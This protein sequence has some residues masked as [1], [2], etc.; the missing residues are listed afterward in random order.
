[1]NDRP[2]SSEAA[3]HL[4]Q[5]GKNISG[6][7]LRRI[8]TMIMSFGILF[9]LARWLGADGLGQYNLAIFFPSLLMTFLNLGVR[10]SNAYHIGQNRAN[11]SVAIRTVLIL[12]IV[13]TGIGVIAGVIL[14]QTFA[15]VLFPDVPENYLW[16]ALCAF[17]ILLL[18]G[19]LFGIVQGLQDFDLLNRL[20][21]VISALNLT[22]V[23]V[24]SV[25][26][27]L[28]VVTALMAY[29]LSQVAGML[30]ALIMLLRYPPIAGTADTTSLLDFG[31]QLVR[32][33]WLLNVSNIMVFLNYRID[34]F[35]INLVLNPTAVGLY[36]TA[37][38]VVEVVWMPSTAVG[39]VLI[40]RIAELKDDES[41]RQQITPLIA[42]WT[43]LVTLC[44]SLV[45]IVMGPV[46][47]DLIGDEYAQAYPVL[48]LLLPGAI[49][50]THSRVLINDVA[51]RGFPKYH[52]YTTF[53]VLI[54]E[55]SLL[56][57]FTPPLGLIG[58]AVA[59]SLA[60]STQVIVSLYF[61]LY[62]TGLSV[63]IVLRPNELDRRV[64]RKLVQ[65]VQR[66]IKLT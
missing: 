64:M 66:A 43:L 54:I 23:I 60:Y 37:V 55:V 25:A 39:Q 30:F 45:I 8:A 5:L 28:T 3:G 17:P 20:T 31:R 12:W 50:I 58:A 65:I 48:I 1:M 62:L 7:I 14:I 2:P 42:R 26:E 40:P 32:Y 61:Y 52:L 16:L 36:Y 15:S 22:L 4:N 6:V 46:I 34:I 19:Y 35:I 24:F 38:R 49:L 10:Q 33:G 56:L 59:S 18:Q 51:A 27:T 21:I 44:V 53:S 9:G 11:L 41:T 47:F 29:I 13:L 63:W 57:L